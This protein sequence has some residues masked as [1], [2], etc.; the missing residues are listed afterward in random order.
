[1]QA[2]GR[3]REN[4]RLP[5]LDFLDHTRMHVDQLGEL[6]LRVASLLPEPAHVF[7]ELL[8]EGV[9]WSMMCVRHTASWRPSQL[10]Y[11]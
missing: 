8:E 9:R 6:F 10:T 11:T 3:R 4:V 5:E 7:P 2:H 1:M